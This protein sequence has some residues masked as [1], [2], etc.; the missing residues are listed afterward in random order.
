MET[1]GHRCRASLDPRG[2]IVCI[3]ALVLMVSETNIF[4]KFSPLEDY[5]ETL[6]HRQGASFDPRGLIGRIYVED[7]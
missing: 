2:F 4:F 3:K 1:L 5:L 6:D 7:H